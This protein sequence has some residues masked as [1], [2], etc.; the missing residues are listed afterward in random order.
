MMAA[1]ARWGLAVAS[2]ALNSMLFA[3]PSAVVHSRSGASLLFRPH[4]LRARH[5]LWHSAVHL[6]M[7]H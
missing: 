1:R 7:H 6:L 4:T 5:F 2:S 3:T